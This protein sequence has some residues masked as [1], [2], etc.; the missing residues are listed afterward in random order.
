MRRI[1]IVNIFLFS[2]VGCE[3]S[4]I[5]INLPGAGEQNENFKRYL[6]E[7]GDSL[8]VSYINNYTNAIAI[9]EIPNQN[10]LLLVDVIS[11]VDVKYVGG[12]IEWIISDYSA[13]LKKIED[14][15]TISCQ[16]VKNPLTN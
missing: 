12:Q 9:L 10:E 3:P 1:I 11:L 5:I 6:C 4:S 13:T 15:D 16:E 8:R 14:K 2:L 7:N